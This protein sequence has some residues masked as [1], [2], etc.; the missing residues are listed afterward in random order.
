MQTKT[1]EEILEQ[2]CPNYKKFL[3]KDGGTLFNVSINGFECFAAMSSYSSHLEERIKMLEDADKWI[4]VMN[5][6][7][8]RDLHYRLEDDENGY[9]LSIINRKK[10]PRVWADNFKDTT[11][12]IIIESTDHLIERNTIGERDWSQRFTGETLKECFEDCEK[13]LLP[14]AP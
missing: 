5:E 7:H 2:H 6:L 1:K 13:W 8:R 9:Y 14:T 10:Y 4:S 11:H 3:E 12:E